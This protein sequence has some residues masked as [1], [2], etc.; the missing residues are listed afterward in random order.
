MQQTILEVKNLTTSFKTERG[1][2]KAIDGI[3]FRV[4]ANESLGIVGESGCG[5]SVTCQSIMRLY[6]KGD[7]LHFDRYDHKN[8][9]AD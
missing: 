5:K 7:T 2:M 6:L 1:V 8:R 3:N 4:N 9:F